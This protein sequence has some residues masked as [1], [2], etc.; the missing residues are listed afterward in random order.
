MCFFFLMIRRPPRS[1]RTDTLFP[2][3]TLFRSAGPDQDDRVGFVDDVDI[4]L[5]MLI[6]GSEEIF[7]ATT[8]RIVE[9]AERMRELAAVHID[10]SNGLAIACKGDRRGDTRMAA[11]SD[12]DYFLHVGTQRE[13]VLDRKRVG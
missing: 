2:Y 12:R 8:D 10:Q 13:L 6:D 9:F 5:Y 7:T 4:D 3:T 11:R 1:T